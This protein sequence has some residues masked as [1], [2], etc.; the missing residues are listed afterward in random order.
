M[1]YIS[2]LIPDNELREL[3]AQ[4]G[5]GVESIEFSVAENLDH[6][7]ETLSSYKERLKT[8]GTDDVILHGP[9]LDLNPVS[10]DR[11][12]RRV[13]MLRYAQAYEAARE[14]GAG[15]IVYHSCMY[16]DIYYA[17]GWAERAADFYR[18]FLETRRDVEVVVENVYDRELMLLV[19]MVEEIEAPNFHLCL[20]VGHANRFAGAVSLKEWARQMHAYVTHVHLHDNDGAWDSHKAL[21]EGTVPL[22]VLGKYLEPGPGRTYT[23]ECGSREAVLKSF[24]ILE[25]LFPDRN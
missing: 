25:K 4:T 8:L 12:I 2:H 17:Q 19:D 6:L 24:Q 22:D 3:I 1:I 13:S 11:E 14:L 21:G 16:P 20:D 15:K 9:F 7:K 10:Y 5:A 18:E 23:I